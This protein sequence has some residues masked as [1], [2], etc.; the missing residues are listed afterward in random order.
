[1]MSSALTP[2][3]IF[4]SY[5]HK[6]EALMQELEIHLS[7]LKRQ[8]LVSTWHDRKIEAGTDW[9]QA[10]HAQ[11][12]QALVILLLV[13]PDFIASD[14]CYQI[15]MQ[16]AVRRHEEN[17][18]RVI[19]I[20]IRPCDWSH[21]PFARLQ[22]LPRDGKPI[23]TWENQDVAW[24]NV[25]AGI[26]RAIEDLPLLTESAPHADLPAIWNIPYPRNPFFIGRDELLLRLHTQLQAGQ[27]TAISQSPQAISGLGGI[28]KTQMAVEYAYRYHQEYEVVLWA[29]A[30]NQETL[31]SSYNTI[32]TLLKLP[33]REVQEQEITLQAIKRW[34]Q[35]H[36]KWLLI[37]DNADNLDLL[38]TYL[39]PIPGGHILLTTRAWDMQRLASRIEVETLPLEQGTLFLL[40]R[41]ALIPPDAALDQ[42]RIEDRQTAMQIV[43][44]LG[45]LP[46]ALD[47]AG[48]YLEATGMSLSQYRQVYQRHRRTLLRERRARVPDHPEPVTTTWSLSF[49]QVE[50][51]NQASAGLLRFCAYLAPDAI[52]ENIITEGAPHLGPRL[53]SVATDPLKLGQAIEA[54]RAYSLVQ[55]D[56]QTQTLSVH[57]L[58]Q[59]VVRDSMTAKAQTQWKQRVVRAVN[60][61]CPN[62]ED[63][64]QWDACERWL[65]HAQMC[66]IWI[67]QEDMTLP[68]AARLL[69]EAGYYL[70]LQARYE[71]AKPLYQSALTIRER[72]LGSEHPD[73][74][75]TLHHLAWLYRDQDQGE[76]AELLY[77]R[78]LA[79][80]ERALGSEHPSTASTLNHLAELYRSQGQYGRAEPLYQRALAIKEKK[81]G[82][83]H[84]SAA[85]T[86][87][88]LAVLYQ[89]QGQYEQAELL[90]LRAL[91]IRDRMPGPKHPY[92]AGT[93]HQ[94]ATL[95]EAQGKYEQAELLYQRALSIRERHLGPQHPDTKTT[96]ENYASLLRAMG[97]DEEAASLETDQ[98]PSS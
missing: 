96:L 25:A 43:Q 29:R 11:L 78:A 23:T 20:I 89:N 16:R 69:N 48:A 53:A 65:P 61:S 77:Q 54:L 57:R 62:V 92:A 98:T 46:L 36:R 40:R 15:E 76:R 12:E 32:A 1:L 59:A 50:E 68:E 51:H 44:E 28:G 39:P 14:Y 74:A 33:E 37:L 10:I 63:V 91:A 38:P 47:Q 9:A 66:A 18:A 70:H 6:D 19:P 30:E 90:Y 94:L 75:T 42:A 56:P 93:L 35:T 49:K 13:S 7:G 45:G 87:H 97:R 67:E 52:P 73:T 5:A 80:R 85:N 41:A 81:L 3:E 34:L 58:V 4:C 71:Q 31:I 8:G 72:A 83:E 22:S 26:R 24:H 84:P 95:Y 55:R 21:T 79:V 2:I 64:A 60:A 88:N 86:L 17:S 27:T 82:R